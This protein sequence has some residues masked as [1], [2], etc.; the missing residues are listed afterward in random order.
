LNSRQNINLA[1]FRLLFGR[2]N[3]R[4]RNAMKSVGCS[5]HGTVENSVL[6]PGVIVEEGAVVRNSILFSDCH[7]SRNATVDL[8]ILDKRVNIGEQAIVGAGEN[9]KTANR[10]KPTHLYTGITLIG[11]AAQVPAAMNIGR[12]CVVNSY[13][14]EE[15]YLEKIVEDGESLFPNGETS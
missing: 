9:Y 7:I 13:I 10:L 3:A 5:I 6:S 11:K 8:S 4:L 14:R 2:P 1:P 15:A 12:N